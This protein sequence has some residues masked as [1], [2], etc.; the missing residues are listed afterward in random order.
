MCKAHLACIHKP[1]MCKATIGDHIFCQPCFFSFSLFLCLIVSS[2]A[3]YAKTPL[4]KK[5]AKA[6]LG[7]EGEDEASAKGG[8]NA[9]KK[10]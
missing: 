10:K 9:K 7:K 1:T 2:Q 4:G 8:K 3:W 6:A 5:R